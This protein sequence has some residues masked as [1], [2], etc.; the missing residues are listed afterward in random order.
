[1][2]TTRVIALRVHHAA[3]AIDRRLESSPRFLWFAATTPMLF[4]Y[5]LTVRVNPQAMGIDTAS[6]TPSAWQ[7]AHHGTPRLPTDG[8]FY[9]WFMMP[10]GSGHVVSNREPGLIGLAAIFY[11]LFPWT[12]IDNVAP[13]SIAAAVVTSAGIG[14]LALLFRRLVR[15]RTALL[16]ALVAGTATSS[17]AVSG[18]SLWPH[19]ADELYLAMAM[20]FVSSAQHARAGLAFA[21]AILTRPPIAVAAAISAVWT[22]WVGR[23]IRPALVIGAITACAVLGYLAYSAKFWGGGLQ[24]QYTALAGTNL[25]GTTVGSGDFVGNL[26]DVGPRAFVGF[27]VNILG[28]LVSPGRGVLVYSPFLI[29]LIPGVRS[30]WR[31]APAWVRS[32]AVSGVAYMA[33]Q[34]KANYFAGGG[35]FWGYRY[36]IASLV[37]CAPLLVLAWQ[38]YASCSARRRA[39]FASLTVAAIASQALGAMCFGDNFYPSNW[40]PHNVYWAL[41][42]RPVLAGVICVA[43]YVTAATS[44]RVVMRRGSVT[45]AGGERGRELDHATPR[46]TLGTADSSVPGA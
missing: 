29:V 43:G 27:G 31:V 8:N 12:S 46:M 39:W 2:I 28:T 34:L 35:N 41:H 3:E 19:S 7:L 15:P 30:A 21:L 37:L 20:L 11:R 14:T 26:F 9:S 18:T 36:P 24:S 6:V 23:S 45:N 25:N 38:V 33:V 40:A 10:S 42:G 44:Y 5:L 13:A 17:W 4:L 22:S 1:M 16:A 32:S